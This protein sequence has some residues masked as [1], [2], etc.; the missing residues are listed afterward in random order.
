M[1]DFRS[2]NNKSSKKKLKCSKE[3]FSVLIT[4]EREKKI[5][6]RSEELEKP[7]LE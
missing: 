6:E 3:M 4:I 2:T 1:V 5:K 7:C